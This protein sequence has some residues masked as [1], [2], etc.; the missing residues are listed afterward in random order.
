LSD[1]SGKHFGPYSISVRAAFVADDGGSQPDMATMIGSI[2]A[3]VVRIPGVLVPEDGPPP[4]FPYVEFGVFCG[5]GDEA[6]V[7]GRTRG[8]SG[9]PAGGSVNVPQSADQPGGRNPVS[10]SALPSKGDSEV[11][12][13]SV[14]AIDAAVPMLATPPNDGNVPELIAQMQAAKRPDAE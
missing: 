13:V 14:G 1:R 2:G 8:D 12:D 5:D 4:S 3:G 7:G 11:R 10:L 6:G 9:E